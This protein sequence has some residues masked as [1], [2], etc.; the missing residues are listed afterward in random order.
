VSPPPGG[1]TDAVGLVSIG[2]AVALLGYLFGAT[3]NTEEVAVQGPSA[4]GWMIGRWQWPGADMSHG[5]LIPLVS[6][7]LAWRLRDDLRRAVRSPSGV[8]LALILASLALYL[9]G[10][11]IQQTRFVLVSLVGLL[12]SIPYFVYGARTARLLMFPCAYLLFCIPLTFLETLT[13]PLRLLSTGVSA[14]V[15]NGIGI[16]VSRVGTAIYFASSNGF[17]LDV[18]HPCSGLRYLM[19]MVALTTAYSYMA[20]TSP[21]RRLT[22][23][24]CSIPLAMAGNIIRILL[25]ALVGLAFG[26][27]AAMGFYHDYS[28]Y[29]VFAIAIILMIWLGGILQR[30][31]PPAAGGAP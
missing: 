26:Q 10:L 25:I 9:A 12:W 17:A 11:R 23:C 14:A 24:L 18:A 27:E 28:G 7:Y 6:V 19:A 21:W 16:A 2:V 20:L 1:R 4:I 22:L 15:L 8:G 30:L 29:V 13:L 3:G 31:R 5:W